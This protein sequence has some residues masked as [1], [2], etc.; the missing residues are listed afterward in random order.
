VARGAFTIGLVVAVI[1]FAVAAT[2][3]YAK[4]APGERGWHRDYFP[5][6]KLTTHDGKTVRFY[7]DLIRGKVVSINF[8]YTKCGDVCPLDTAQLREVHKLLGDRVGRDV[9]M[10]SISLDPENDTPSA[11]TRYM[12]NFDVG[13]GW[14]FLTGSRA[15]IALLQKKL[16]IRP[17]EEG[18]LRQHD[19]RL[20]M[21]NEKTG[22]WVKRTPY[23]DPQLLANMLG[24]SLSN[25]AK[26]PTGPVRPYDDAKE[27]K[28]LSQGRYLFR[29]RCDACHTIG[30]GDKLGPD[31]HGV[32]AAR[33][34][35][36]LKRW[37]KEPDKMLAEGD[38]VA[39]ALKAKYR[40]LPMPNYGLGDLD[41]DAL[42]EYMTQ[43]DKHG[44]AEK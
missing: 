15:D 36:W 41:A 8:I 39:L 6:V 19:T 27:I 14:T 42:I 1:A 18:K 20:I 22:S 44:Q 2:P 21:G 32:A 38:P 3:A 30:G 43:E 34:P 40:N 35:E 10:Y 29:T 28:N 31:L 33:A 7:D 9:F 24:V 16:G 12:H 23:D 37:L 11:L 5:N 13:P 25:Y 26:D 4:P 17:P